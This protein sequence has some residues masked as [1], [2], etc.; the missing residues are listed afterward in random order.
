LGD[1]ISFEYN[2]IWICLHYP[3]SD[4]FDKNKECSPHLYSGLVSK[5]WSKETPKA[6]HRILIQ[7]NA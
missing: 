2:E 1:F 7:N 6:A 3:L 5:T 4:I